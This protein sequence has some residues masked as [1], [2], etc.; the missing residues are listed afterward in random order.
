MYIA[1]IGGQNI[2]YLNIH[3]WN[4]RMK[5]LLNLEKVVAHTSCLGELQL[6][7]KAHL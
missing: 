4:L 2:F 6:L 5:T 3:E 1:Y 7:A